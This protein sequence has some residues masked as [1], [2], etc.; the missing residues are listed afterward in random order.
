MSSR[1]D[2]PHCEK[3]QTETHYPN[4]SV[5]DGKCH[6]L[7]FVSS[8]PKLTMKNFLLSIS[9]L[10]IVFSASAQ[11]T[12]TQS[13][14]APLFTMARVANDTSPT[15]G[16]GNPG[17]N[18]TYNLSALANDSIDTLTFSLPQF[19]PNG[20][21]YPNSNRVIIQGTNGQ[22]G[23]IYCTQSATSLQMDGVVADPGIGQPVNLK[24]SLFETTVT[25]PSTLNTSFS[26][27]L[28]T[29]AK[30]Y[31]G[32]DPGLGFTLDSI[33]IRSHVIKNSMIDGWGN[34][35]TPA[36]TY[37]CLRQN[38]TRQN[39]DSIWGYNALILGG[40]AYL[41][42][43]MDSNRVYTYWAS[44]IGYPVAQLTD[45]QEQGIITSGEY[46]MT[47]AIAGVTEHSN[48]SLISVYPN[49]ATEN[50][51]FVT[52]ANTISEIEIYDITGK[53]IS[54][55]EVINDNTTVNVSD[56]A[57]GMYFYRAIDANGN[58]IDRGKFNVAH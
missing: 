6:F 26:N 13:D 41:F 46:L 39:T 4:F 28:V 37:A 50:I 15:V 19:T 40:W 42:S 2:L 17:T 36:G 20:N 11:I 48:A 43:Q 21:L 35:T 47:T 23:S 31:Y 54:S 25:F 55:S 9:A 33:Q 1:W 44:A 10:A 18:Q 49:P 14:M 22:F 3:I 45:R 34:V 38:V 24:D 8:K 57:S 58:V 12:I 29:H 16:A 56:F 27:N 53:I 5:S 52:K 32:Q 51:N 7:T 30:F